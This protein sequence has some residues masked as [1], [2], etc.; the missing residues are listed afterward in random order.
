LRESAFAAVRPAGHRRVRPAGHAL[1]RCYA[2]DA[3]S[4]PFEEAAEADLIEAGRLVDR[5]REENAAGA[6]GRIALLMHRAADPRVGGALVRLC[7]D[8]PFHATGSQ[9]FW[10]LVFTLL[11]ANLDPRMLDSLA[12]IPKALSKIIK[13][14]REG[15]DRPAGPIRSGCTPWR[16]TTRHLHQR[17]AARR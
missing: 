12:Y 5:L 17:R 16:R 6:T 9:P 8:P 1:A 11:D 15:A 7:A 10:R 13:R 3:A 4:P 2:G 14:R